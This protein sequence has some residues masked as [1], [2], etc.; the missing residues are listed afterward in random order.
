M[1]GKMSG[2]LLKCDEHSEKTTNILRQLVTDDEFTDVTL[3]SEDGQSLQAHK[4]IVG[5]SSPYL[6]FL[7]RPKNSVV[8]LPMK[9]SFIRSMLEFIYLGETR[10]ELTEVKNFLAMA[11]QFKIRGLWLEESEEASKIKKDKKTIIKD[12]NVE[13][14]SWEG[15]E[16]QHLT[17]MDDNDKNNVHEFNKEAGTY[18][19]KTENIEETQMKVENLK[20]ANMGR[21]VDTEERKYK[22]DT[23]EYSTNNT[24]H[25]QEHFNNVH[26]PEYFF[27]TKCSYRAKTDRK[28]KSHVERQHEQEVLKMQRNRLSNKGPYFCDKCTYTNAKKY[29]LNEHVKNVHEAARVH[30]E[31]C[32]YI[33]TEKL[34]KVHMLLHT[35]PDLV[36]EKCAFTT[37]KPGHLKE[38]VKNVHFPVYLYCDECPYKAKVLTYL[39]L[40]KQ[41]EHEG[42]MFICD[43][44]DYKT[45]FKERLKDHKRGVHEGIKYECDQCEYASIFRN[46]LFNHKQAVHKMVR[47]GCK[48]CS[49]QAKTGYNLRLH[50]RN[51][52]QIFQ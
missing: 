36:C 3:V 43:Q 40:H 44:C 46:P 35:G 48:I 4:A 49:Y 5:Y 41:R 12:I 10:V 23:C 50:Q 33:G 34:L 47:H 9:H 25:L 42:K 11:N 16:S 45:G 38:H 39:K 31:Y 17:M 28:L 26:T 24:G 37:R 6:N 52:H 21:N 18:N 29:N 27:C 32:D 7:L 8:N 19:N 20:H 51:V 1:N 2:I 30:C 14:D 13:E 15:N 22:C